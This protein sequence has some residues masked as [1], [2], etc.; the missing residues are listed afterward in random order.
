ML[1]C[2]HIQIQAGEELVPVLR[3]IQ[4]SKDQV[5]KKPVDFKHS[6]FTLDFDT[7]VDDF[8]NVS[9]ILGNISKYAHSMLSKIIPLSGQ[10]PI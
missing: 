2:H 4:V 6:S 3:S 7:D 1:R 10:I 5:S 8:L 9:C